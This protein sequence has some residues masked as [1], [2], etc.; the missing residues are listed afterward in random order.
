MHSPPR[1]HPNALGEAQDH[2]KLNSKTYGHRATTNSRH[3]TARRRG[4]ARGILEAYMYRRACAC[5][6]ARRRSGEARA[7]PRAPRAAAGAGRRAAPPPRCPPLWRQSSASRTHLGAPVCAPFSDG[8]PRHR[9][10]AVLWA[11]G[12]FPRRLPPATP[13]FCTARLLS[14][15]MLEMYGVYGVYGV[16]FRLSNQNSEKVREREASK[17]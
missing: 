7:R 2:I 5:S 6:L 10:G 12:R 13:V 17:K 16:N 11:A 3:Q 1:P 9:C 4:G 14:A 15:A 8:P